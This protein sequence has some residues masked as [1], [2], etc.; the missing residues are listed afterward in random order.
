[1]RDRQRPARADLGEEDRDHAATTAQHV[2][3]AYRHEVPP[4]TR[5]GILH[6]HLRHALGGAHDAGRADSLIGGNQD[7]VLGVRLPG[8]ARHV[9]SP[10]DVVRDGIGHVGFHQRHVLVGGGMEHRVGT[11]VLEDT[12]DPG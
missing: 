6:D 7:E 4:V 2:A 1:M 10:E 8:A 11:E 5:G 9:R 12:P 3:E